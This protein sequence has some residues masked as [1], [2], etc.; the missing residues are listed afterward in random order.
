[1]ALACDIRDEAQVE[2]AVADT[3]RHFG[4][5]D[6]CINNASAIALTGT[7]ETPMKRYDLMHGVNGRGTFLVSKLCLPHLLKSANP[8]ILMISPP[9]ELRPEWFGPHL[10]YSSAKYAMSL[11][12][13]GLAEEFRGRVAVNALWPRTMIA[14]AAIRNI[15]GG[16]D[17][18]RRA[19]KPA[20]VADA[21]H[22]IFLKP[23]SFTGNFLI[24]D[25]FLAAEGL[26]DFAQYRVDPSRDLAQDFFVPDRPV[27]PEPLDAT[28]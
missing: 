19:R 21:A 22:R 25:S 9:L 16:D 27:P 26:R 5:I 1:L 7:L 28:T 17:M 11:A 12:V 24:D 14:T 2:K 10:A 3:V 13:L 15:I 18:M 20:I 4:G 23:R 8:H 6:I